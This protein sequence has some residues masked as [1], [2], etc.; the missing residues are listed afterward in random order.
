MDTLAPPAS[1]SEATPRFACQPHCLLTETDGSQRIIEW[2]VVRMPSPENP[3][4][5]L[6]MVTKDESTAHLFAT[7]PDLLTAL[8]AYVEMDEAKLR[9]RYGDDFARMRAADEWKAATA[10]IAKA[11]GR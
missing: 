3:G 7:A 9:R 11:E 4:G 6:V 1:T 5:M 10:A 2:R 8:R